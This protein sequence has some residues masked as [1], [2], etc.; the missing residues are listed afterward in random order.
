MKCEGGRRG[1]KDAGKKEGK[2]S[3]KKIGLK[4]REFKKT[5][6][7]RWG[8]VETGKKQSLLLGD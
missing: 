7:R 2:K 8:K 6:K 3:R 1:K 4:N 5:I